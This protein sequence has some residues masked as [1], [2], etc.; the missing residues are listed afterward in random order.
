VR[1]Q[2]AFGSKVI[3]VM[4]THTQGGWASKGVVDGKEEVDHLKEYYTI[5]H[6]LT[7]PI[8]IFEGQ[9]KPTDDGG[10]LPEP[11]PNFEA[12]GVFGYPQVVVVD[13][14]GVIRQV[15]PSLSRDDEERVSTKLHDL[16]NS[17][18]GAATSSSSSR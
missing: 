17:G 13:Q 9:K 3:V 1:I 2:G 16:I 18:G 6:K 12:F 5:E 11:D 8:A 7:F 10:F 4:E 15:L 14:K